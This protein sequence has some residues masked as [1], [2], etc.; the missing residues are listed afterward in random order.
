MLGLVRPVVRVNDDFSN[1]DPLKKV[2]GFA[3]RQLIDLCL[4]PRLCD[5]CRAKGY[6]DP[7]DEKVS[8]IY[9]PREKHLSFNSFP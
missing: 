3:S 2:L 7:G 5:I 8:L 4:D 6:I 9:G 1:L